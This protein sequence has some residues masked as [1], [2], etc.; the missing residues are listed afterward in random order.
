MFNG[1][2]QFTIPG[3]NE[4]TGGLFA[5][6]KDENSF[7]FS[8]LHNNSLV[9]QIKGFIQWEIEYL[10]KPPQSTTSS[11]PSISEELSRLAHLQAQGALSDEEFALLKRRIIG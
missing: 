3:G 5:A 8:G 9:N 6:T 2:L 7:V 1:F 4:S 11:Q 10:H